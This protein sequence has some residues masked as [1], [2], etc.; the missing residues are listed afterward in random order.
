M[1]WWRKIGRMSILVRS[2]GP[3]VPG[4]VAWTDGTVGPE[5]L[6]TERLIESIYLANLWDAGVQSCCSEPPVICGALERK[7]DQAV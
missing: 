1:F 7:A 3:P 4:S 2:L 6:C 5:Y